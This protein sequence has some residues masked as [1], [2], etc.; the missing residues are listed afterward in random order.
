M[1]Y[2]HCVIGLLLSVISAFG[3]AQS[4]IQLLGQAEMR[5]DTKNGKLQISIDSIKNLDTVGISG[6]LR[7]RLYFLPEKYNGTT[8]NG[9]LTGESYFKQKIP[10]NSTAINFKTD[11]PFYEIPKGKYYKTICLEEMIDGEYQIINFLNFENQSE[12]NYPKLSFQSFEKAL[13]QKVKRSVH[14]ISGKCLDE[15][16]QLKTFPNLAILHIKCRDDKLHENISTFSTLKHLELNMP[17][18]ENLPND[19]SNLSALE[20]FS[21]TI[22]S[23]KELPESVSAWKNLKSL[24]ISY[25]AIQALP[26]SIGDLRNLE[27]LKLNDNEINQL[28]ASFTQLE[29]LKHLEINNTNIQSLPENLGELSNLQHL[30]CRHSEISEIP[31][32]AEQLKSLKH[33]DISGTNV[34]KIPSKLI[35]SLGALEYINLSGTSLSE[36]QMKR[37]KKHV[38]EHCKVITEIQIGE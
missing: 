26:Q 9:F 32:S 29:N 31:S 34:N 7:L 8:V 2:K 35:K 11:M 13:D 22:S 4:N 15:N 3:Y 12:V 5:L 25:T 19:I 33:L 17:N 36:R 14:S 20:R 30:E 1:G 23:L 21:C 27:T 18:I 38:P 10:A 6:K 37:I 28:P 24:D 16:I